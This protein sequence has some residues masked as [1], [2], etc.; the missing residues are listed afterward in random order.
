MKK[1]IALYERGWQCRSLYGYFCGWYAVGVFTKNPS[2]SMNIEKAT[3]FD[4]Q[5]QEEMNDIIKSLKSRIGYSELLIK[6]EEI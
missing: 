4:E 6:T 3:V 2:L 5:H 1:I